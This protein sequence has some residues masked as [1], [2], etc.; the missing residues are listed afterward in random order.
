MDLNST[1]DNISTMLSTY[2]QAQYWHK[3][4]DT[5]LDYRLHSDPNRNWRSIILASRER[6]I[7]GARNQVDIHTRIKYPLTNQR[8]R[9]RSR[10]HHA[11]RGFIEVRVPFGAHHHSTGDSNE[12]TQSVGRSDPG[13]LA[14]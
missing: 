2:Q 14:W 10:K 4:D 6:G 11:L 1:A 9:L 13:A 12:R 7:K 5:Q 8:N 3:I